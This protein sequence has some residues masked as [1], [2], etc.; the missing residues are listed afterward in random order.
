MV[1]LFGTGEGGGIAITPTGIV[2]LPRFD[3]RLLNRCK[4]VSALIKADATLARRDAG[5]ELRELADKVARAI[6]PVVVEQAG[7]A[8]T[9]ENSI[10]YI[11]PD[12]GFVCG[13]TG[14]PPQAV[15][16]PTVGPPVQRRE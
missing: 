2:K 3:A 16:W 1:I 10:V 11:D 6:V 15:P 8:A 7:D 12:G 4:A 9:G 13:T 14:K 5:E